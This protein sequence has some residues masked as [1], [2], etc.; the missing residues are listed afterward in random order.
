MARRRLKLA[1][2]LLALH[3]LATPALALEPDAGAAADAGSEAAAPDEA[4]ELFPDRAELRERWR[5][6]TPE[7]RDEIRRELRR[8]WREADPKQRETLRNR[9]RARVEQL[10]PDERRALRRLK[11]RLGQARG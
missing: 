4:A 8:R 5:N 1:A 11:L 7:Q 10:P 6:A 3:A 2:A 9:V